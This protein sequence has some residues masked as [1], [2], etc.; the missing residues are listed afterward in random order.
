[1]A[2]PCWPSNKEKVRPRWRQISLL[3]MAADGEG[4]SGMA[5]GK[6]IGW[7][8]L[9]STSKVRK[10]A[11]AAAASELLGV[12]VAL[13]Y[14]LLSACAAASEKLPSSFACTNTSTRLPGAKNTEPSD[15][16][17]SHSSLLM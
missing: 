16:S 12:R 8:R 3:G 17:V 5:V 2:P 14:A 11:G 6:R 9:P 1:P 13:A 7:A 4:S 10:A 15:S